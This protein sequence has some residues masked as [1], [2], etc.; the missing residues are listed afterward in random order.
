M[1]RRFL[2]TVILCSIIPLL[3]AAAIIYRTTAG[4]IRRDIEGALMLE[5]EYK[6][7]EI[8][9][10]LSLKKQTQ[11]ILSGLGMFSVAVEYQRFEGL[12]RFFD[13]MMKNEKGYAGVCFLD[14]NLKIQANN[15]LSSE[16]RYLRSNRT[17][18]ARYAAGADFK[19]IRP[20]QFVNTEG[21][22][23]PVLISRILSGAGNHIGY[24]LVVLNRGEFEALLSSFAE[25]YERLN[26]VSL[27]YLAAVKVSETYTPLVMSGGFDPSGSLQAAQRSGISESGG[28]LSVWNTYGEADGVRTYFQAPATAL[29]SRLR[30]LRVV[31]FALIPLF[32]LGMGFLIVYI[33]KYSFRS[34]EV[35]LEKM[36]AMSKGNYNRIERAGFSGDKYINY[37]N[38]LI[39]RI[40][41]YEEAY[42]KE[43]Q[44]SALGKLAAQ[45]AHDIRSPLAALNSVLKDASQLPEEKRLMI[46]GAVG[47]IGDIANN[48]LEKNRQ[49]KT[50]AGQSAEKDG[51][52]PQEPIESHLLSSLIEPVI[53]EKRLQF[54]DKLEVGIDSNLGADSYGLFAK[55]QLV[56]FGRVLSNLINNSVEAMGRSG[57]VVLSLLHEDAR[58]VIKIRDT[59]KGIP[60]E[61]LAKLGQRGATHG[62]A[63][64]S[65]LGLYH[66]KTTMESW[67]GSLNI[68][69]EVGKG[70]TLTLT[71]PQA[72][73]PGWFVSSLKLFANS[74]VVILD[75]D[76]SIH[77]VWKWRFESS[78]VKEYGI[79]VSNF[80]APAGL[81]EWFKSNPEESKK[82]VYLFDYELLGHKETGLS[83]AEELG[84]IDKTIL[85]TSRYEEP[86]VMESCKRLGLRLI[87]K[88]LAGLVPI[89]VLET[90]KKT[91]AVPATQ[92]A[93]RQVVLLDDDILVHMN[94]KMAAMAAGEELKAYKT[95]ENFYVEIGNLPKDT[96]I[97]IDSDLGNN[98]KGEDIAKDLRK[99]GF[100]TIAMATGYGPEKFAHLPWLKV[101]GKEP[102]FEK[103]GG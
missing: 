57:S 69:S 87:P 22:L 52:P 68:Q 27:R 31:Y 36:E 84:V 10:Y 78:Q 92:T 47:R 66:A 101:T 35:L 85:V 95:P 64:G 82:A 1:N 54:R 58:V 44:L 8:Y 94:W 50:S 19:S 11:A 26:G 42:R 74:P 93:G 55:I 29:F 100:T 90:E 46:R 15:E 37:A 34:I 98:V 14:R 63:G 73:P 56:E 79:T 32:V 62:K 20:W 76:T 24:L 99:K 6:S 41:S 70:T 5:A 16:G 96:P 12:T 89:S 23:T 60:P 17:V 83:L 28:K 77:Q 2:A 39:D 97:Y 51:P 40:L 81:R 49:S 43:V 102:P 67:G 103:N 33:T 86:D 53:T 38:Q 48:L 88:N 3:V 30:T 7:R 75:D 25:K 91:S 9:G 21:V 71:L 61:M 4:K 80:S 59:G 13:S 18:L 45:V 65:G 72:E